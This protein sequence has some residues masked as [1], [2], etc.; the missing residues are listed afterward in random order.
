MDGVSDAASL[1]TLVQLAAAIIS[2][3]KNVADAP[4]QRRQ[5]LAAL[6]QA[7]GLLLT[8]VEL[9][10][11]VDDED[12]SHTIQSL[13]VRNGPLST[14]QSLLE[15]I[16]RKLDATTPSSTVAVSLKRFR[17]PFERTGF[18]EMIASLE[19]L[20]S[21]FLLA[22]A[23]DHL[24]LSMAIRNEL[25]DMHGQLAKTAIDAQRRTL[26]SLSREQELIVN[27]LSL[28]NLSGKVD[29]DKA[30]EMRTG[31]EWFLRHD[32]FKQWHR[33]SPSPSTLVLTGVPGSGKS[34]IC[35][36]TRFF[37]KA[38]HQSEIDVCVAYVSFNSLHAEK[39]SESLVL[40][41][42]VQQIVLERPYLMGH[43]AALSVT[44]GPLS[45]SE[46]VELICRACR[47]LK[48]F[49]LIL[50][51]LDECGRVG[52]DV[53]K[54]LLAIRPALSILIASRPEKT[55]LRTL[56]DCVIINMDSALTF[57]GHLEAVKKLLEGNPRIAGFLDND[58]EGIANAA[59]RIVEKSQGM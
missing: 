57:S 54:N 59:K 4:V 2:Y 30:M 45:S 51:G 3:V 21:H 52:Q 20:K 12:W 16:A 25:H 56:Q 42:I 53:V 46:S 11:E 43:V 9:T 29:G 24:R 47:D 13:S 1:I 49:Y 32:G 8:L 41:N 7:R 35:Q 6:V 31:T 22:I 19:Q 17:W 14:F 44:G 40:S 33:A 38:W 34:S 27:S 48:H 36:V 55:I 28:E 5:L 18:Q 58:P 10:N 15:E 37:L 26:V 50:D 39:L 23:N